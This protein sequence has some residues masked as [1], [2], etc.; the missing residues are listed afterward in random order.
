MSDR[1][2][3]PSHRD[4]EQ[5]SQSKGT[6]ETNDVSQ[7]PVNHSTSSVQHARIDPRSLSRQD[8]LH[9]Q[10]T[11]GNRAV[12]RLLGKAKT[13]QIPK[14]MAVEPDRTPDVQS[15]RVAQPIHLAR[16]APTQALESIVARKLVKPTYEGDEHATAVSLDMK[17]GDTLDSG[18]EPSVEPSGWTE[19]GDM[20]LTKGKDNNHQWIRFHVLNQKAGGAGDEKGNLTPATQTANHHKSWNGLEKGLKLFVDPEHKQG[21]GA[22]APAK[23]RAKVT[24]YGDGEDTA[25]TDGTDTVGVAGKN[26]PKKI[27]AKLNITGGEYSDPEYSADLDGS[28]AGLLKPSEFTPPGW[29]EGK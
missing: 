28:G 24:Y 21:S 1:A 27:E 12:T 6:S 4:P 17:K 13:P 9:L 22:P 15:Q 10:R 26:Y 25:W 5:N 16:S 29:K 19:L 2:S 11:I 18:S 3:V 8:V 20:G 14:P 7:S 23:F